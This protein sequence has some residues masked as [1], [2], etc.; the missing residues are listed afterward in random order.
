MEKG[1]RPENRTESASDS[2]SIASPLAVCNSWGLR[3]AP[4]G[5]SGKFSPALTRRARHHTLALSFPRRALQASRKGS[6]ADGQG[7]PNQTRL[8][9]APGGAAARPGRRAGGPGGLV[10]RRLG[11]D[12]LP[13]AEVPRVPRSHLPGRILRHNRDQH[14]VLPAPPAKP[15]RAMVDTRGGEPAVSVHRETL[16]EIHARKRSHR[17]RRARRPDGI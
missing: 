11:W 7:H 16:A 3:L 13:G 1:E 14:V 5:A 15:L 10:L 12:R 17:G 4:T 8:V 6:G 2:R 9:G